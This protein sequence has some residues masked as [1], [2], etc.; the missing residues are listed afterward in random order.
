M[1]LLHLIPGH[2]RVQRARMNWQ[3]RH[4]IVVVG[5]AVAHR[6]SGL[7][8]L[9]EWRSTA[10]CKRSHGWSMAQCTSAKRAGF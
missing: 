2:E 1:A 6:A 5:G 4:G 3:Q 7:V 9:R 8:D 10:L